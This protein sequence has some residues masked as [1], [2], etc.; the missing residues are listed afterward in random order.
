MTEQQEFRFCD[1][2]ITPA[3]K[4]RLSGQRQ[5]ILD[6]LRRGPA[7]NKELAMLSLKYTGR[8]SDLRKSGYDVRLLSQDR[9]TGVSVYVLEAE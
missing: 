5:A 9:A 7:T 3:E 4:P 1:H 6:R 2:R 8:I